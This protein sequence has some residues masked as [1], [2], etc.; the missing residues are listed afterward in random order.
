MRLVAGKED[1]HD[2]H[3]E[4]DTQIEGKTHT[5]KIHTG[6]PRWP[7]SPTQLNHKEETPRVEFLVRD[8]LARD[9]I[10]IGEETN[11]LDRI[12]HTCMQ[13]IQIKVEFP[14]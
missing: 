8:S 4:L 2:E 7:D 11:Q 9:R 14:K 3:D 12:T 1:E 13:E 5:H 10:P 6:C